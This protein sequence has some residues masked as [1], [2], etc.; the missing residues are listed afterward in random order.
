MPKNKKKLAVKN[1]SMIKISD[2]ITIGIV[3]LFLTFV[4]AGLL[5]E[6]V[7]VAIV[8]SIAVE[9]IFIVIAFALRRREEAPYAY[10]RL[11]LEL[12]I[13]GPSFL[14]E[15]LKTILKNEAFESGFNYILLENTLFYV[16]FKFGNVTINDLPGIYSTA[17]KHNKTNVFLFARGIDR[18]ALRLLESYG[19][20]IKI[21]RIRQIF[22]LL[23]K[24][25]LLP[26]LNK[27]HTF[28]LADIPALFIA[29]SNFK[30]LLFSGVVLLCTAFFTPLKIYYIIL[31]STSLLLAIICLSP[32]GKESP[33]QRQNLK[34]LFS[35]IDTNCDLNSNE[36]PYSPKDCNKKSEN[37]DDFHG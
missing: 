11:A 34:E 1:Q 8:V 21:V 3:I 33:R 30:G 2:F 26:D 31:G 9:G 16:N 24:H 15:K 29:K 13:Q 17:Q 25:N 14:V 7:A 23:K 28:K 27:K 32:L 36:T 12:S 6:N 35:A 19:I 18:K 5:F 37:D 10:D 22:K 4:W 20:F